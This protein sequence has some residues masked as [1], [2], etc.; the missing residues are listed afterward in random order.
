MI[1]SYLWNSGGIRSLL[2]CR[3]FTPY[4]SEYVNGDTV[5]H[6]YK[7]TISTLKQL[8]QLLWQTLLSSI[9]PIKQSVQHHQRYDTLFQLI[10]SFTDRHSTFFKITFNE[11]SCYIN[12]RHQL[13]CIQFWN[14]ILCYLYISNI[15]HAKFQNLN[16]SRLVLH[17]SL[18]NPLKPG[19]K[20]TMKM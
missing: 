3:F 12:L 16:A 1:T 5:L 7:N 9:V 20:S 8:D 2:L 19:V 17:L 14:I 10:Y 4:G 13:S 15:R 6:I 18:P 11:L